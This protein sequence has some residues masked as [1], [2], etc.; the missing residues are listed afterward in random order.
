LTKNLNVTFNSNTNARIETPYVQVNKQLYPDQYA[1]WKDSVWQSI[2]SL[3]R[4]LEYRQTFMANYTVPFR[5]IPALNFLSASLTFNSDYTWQKGALL[6]DSTVEMGNTISN[7]RT[8]GI[9]NATINLL[10]LYNKSSFLSDANKKYTL[11]RS[12]APVVAGKPNA[13]QIA[14][15]TKNLKAAEDKKK[16]TFEAIVTLNPDSAITVKHQLDNKRVR[17]TAR[18]DG[19]KLYDIK[20]KS[21][22]NNSISIKNKDSVNLRLVISQLPPLEDERW[23]KIAQGVARGLMMVRTIGFSYN[24]SADMTIPYFRPNIGSFTGQGS[25]PLGNAPGFDFAF[26]LTGLDYINKADRQGWLI[27][28]STNITP[29]LMNQ[30]ENFKFTAQLEPVVGM[31]ITL[32][33]D[34]TSSKMNQYYFMF[35][36]QPPQ[37][38]G[39]FQMSTISI[40]SAFESSNPA[41]GYYSKTFQTFLNNRN[42]VASRLG[43]AYKNTNYPTGGFLEGNTDLAGKPFDPSIGAIGVNSTD[44]LIPAFISAYTGG[45][46]AS[47]GLSAFPSLLK[48]LPN[49]SV[50]YDG[51]M[52]IPFINKR[53]RSFSLEHRYSSIYAVGA[54]NSFMNWI[55]ANGTD[56]GYGFIQ[57]ITNNNP[58]PSSPYD[59]TMV[60]ITEA[61]TPLIGLTSTFLNNVSLSLKYN[62][63]R[64][65]SL[66]ISSYQIAEMLKNDITFGTGYR[67]DNFNRILK[68]RKTG[69]ADFNNELKLDF[70]VTY[71]KMQSLIRKIEDGLTQAISGNAQTMIKLSAD[72]SLSKMITLQGYFDKQISNP[73]ISATAYPLT[74]TDFGINVRVNFT[75]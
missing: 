52:Q 45:N 60:S 70:A 59:I 30:T 33:A 71:S 14:A 1:Q 69:G 47:V 6:A 43:E 37:L 75:R 18:G 46:P 72:Y 21:L 63:T 50:T 51:L 67:F 68:I 16:K 42:I 73:L 7:N 54:Y 27:K 5:S 31:R 62:K 17:V 11:K 66:N 25:S 53:F 35:N 58:I 41:N 9:N 49:W 26:G 20:F 44:V 56:P 39:N 15:Q 74:K 38:S 64:N 12:S 3:G 32:N 61:F 23:Y 13:R 48:L 57:N 24:Q 65:I 55:T 34:R 8:F 28:D 2:R 19:G 22:D 4:P 29:A 36:N 40:G 10:A